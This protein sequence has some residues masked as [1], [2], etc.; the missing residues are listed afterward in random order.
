MLKRVM[1]RTGKALIPLGVAIGIAFIFNALILIIAPL[2]V[3]GFLILL[4]LGL[5]GMWAAVD[6]KGCFMYWKRWLLL[7]LAKDPEPSEVAIALTRVEGIA[8]IV[9]SI[10]GLV[11]IVLS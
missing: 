7:L 5:Y 11:K 6:P 2:K 9:I 3:V 10:I 1:K 4:L 8:I